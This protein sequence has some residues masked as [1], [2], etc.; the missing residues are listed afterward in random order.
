[1]ALSCSLLQ[2]S[3]FTHCAPRCGLAAIVVL[4]TCFHSTFIH[5]LKNE[6]QTEAGRQPNPGLPRRREGQVLGFMC[7]FLNARRRAGIC[8]HAHLNTRTPHAAPHDKADQLV[9]LRVCT[10][11]RG[12]LRSRSSGQCLACVHLEDTITLHNQSHRS[13]KR[14]AMR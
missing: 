8:A 11:V 5:S 3:G 10:S 1:M 13:S 12:R 6:K 4:L 14:I 2:R 9:V 7:G